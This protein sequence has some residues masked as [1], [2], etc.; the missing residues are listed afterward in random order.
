MRLRW[1]V[2]S[3]ILGFA[4]ATQRASAN[5]TELDLRELIQEAINRNPGLKAD[6]L[7]A[8]SKEAEIAP[9]GAYEDPMLEFEAMN[10]PVDTLSPREFGM[11]GRQLSLTQKIPFPG[12]LSKLKRSAT[13]AYQSKKDA[14]SGRQLELVRGVKMAYFELFMAQ[15]TL[16]LVREQRNVIKQLIGVTQNKY[17]LGKVSQAELLNLQVEEANLLG[18]QLTVEKQVAAKGAEL[19]FLLGRESSDVP[20]T[21][22]KIAVTPVDFKKLTEAKLLEHG[23]EHNPNLKAAQAEFQ[24]A[25]AQHSFASWNF[26]PDFELRVAYTFRQPTMEDRGVDV[27]SGAVGFSLPIWFFSRQTPELRGASLMRARADALV[28]QSR[29]EL[30]KNLHVTYSEL[31]EANGKIHL[32]ESGLLPLA[33]QAVVTGRAAYL[34]GRLEYVALLNLVNTRFQTETEYNEALVTYESKIAELETLLGDSLGAV[35]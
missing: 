30:R 9:R 25:D 7:E 3:V 27:L 19:S 15:K 5:P 2:L 6:L 29:N 14:F 31:L 22:R 23:L 21:V 1:I 11:T 13:H 33:R 20:G 17:S 16:E 10:Y 8:S 4:G 18:R 26:L 28:T 34:A 24:A 12:K 32:F 35:Q